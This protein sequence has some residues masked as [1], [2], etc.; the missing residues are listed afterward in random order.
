VLNS[1]REGAPGIII[2]EYILKL[3]QSDRA[4]GCISFSTS[5]M[6]DSTIS[7]ANKGLLLLMAFSTGVSL[8]YRLFS[9]PF[10]GLILGGLG[11]ADRVKLRLQPLC[12]NAYLFACPL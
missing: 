11:R 8:I 2:R 1:S 9:L 3:F 6:F 10:I 5:L 7:K 4:R 12:L